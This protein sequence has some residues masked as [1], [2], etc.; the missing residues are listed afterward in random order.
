MNDYGA[1]WGIAV[2]L[3]LLLLAAVLLFAAVLLWLSW[4]W[5]RP[6]A[7]FRALVFPLT[8]PL[9]A[10]LLN[11]RRGSVP[12]FSIAWIGF[13]SVIAC[14]IWG[15]AIWLRPGEDGGHASVRR[16]QRDILLSTV[17]VGILYA[18]WAH[19]TLAEGVRIRE[20]MDGHLRQEA[21]NRA[22]KTAEWNE[23][24]IVTAGGALCYSQ[25]GRW[26]A[27]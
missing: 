24:R 17:V 2:L 21:E 12:S 25:D 6:G 8:L 16:R 18:A 20:W 4:K 11:E 22:R 1:G 14:G 7:S 9:G 23:G 27:V 15:R 5:S 3:G 13:W 19:R 10:M 26:L